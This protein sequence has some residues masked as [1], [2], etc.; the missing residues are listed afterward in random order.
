MPGAIPDPYRV[1]GVPRTATQ[2]QI[3]EAFATLAKTLHPDTA[4]VSRP[5]EFLAVKEAYDCLRTPER[6]RDFDASRRFG[7]SEL[8][9]QFDSAWYQ[10]R[11]SEFDRRFKASAAAHARRGLAQAAAAL[12]SPKALL[13]LLPIALLAS[14]YFGHVA[15]A[16]TTTPIP[17]DDSDDPAPST[18]KRARSPATTRSDSRRPLL[19]GANTIPNVTPAQLSDETP[20]PQ[21][22]RDSGSFPVPHT[23]VRASASSHPLVAASQPNR[24]WMQ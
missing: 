14:A 17:C 8:R 22:D 13:A 12:S 19:T 20:P 21:G 6:R 5:E 7:R 4:G 1:L 24:R 9:T 11:A 3:G 16:A 10:E 18:A 23:A 15:T 2:A